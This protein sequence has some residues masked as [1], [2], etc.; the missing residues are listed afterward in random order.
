MC[1]FQVPY[2]A[3]KEPIMTFHQEPNAILLQKKKINIPVYFA[4]CNLHDEKP[5]QPTPNSVLTDD[6]RRYKPEQ[7]IPSGFPQQGSK[8]FSLPHSRKE[9]QDGLTP[10]GKKFYDNLTQLLTDRSMETSHY[11]I[12]K[13]HSMICKTNSSIP[14]VQMKEIL[15]GELYYNHFAELENDILAL[16]ENLIDKNVN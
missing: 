3:T 16:F 9:I 1:E 14:K 7:L 12:I 6:K 13:Y 15:K 8:Q 4:T 11:S 5:A 2:R 10:Q